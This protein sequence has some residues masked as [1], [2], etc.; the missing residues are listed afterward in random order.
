VVWCGVVWC[1]V[2]CEDL[3]RLGLGLGFWFFFIGRRGILI[4][5][6]G[7]GIFLYRDVTP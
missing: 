4:I 2:V 7:R 6:R 1:G 5:F 3:L